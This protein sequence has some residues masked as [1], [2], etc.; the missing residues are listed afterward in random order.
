MPKKG[1]GKW[2]PAPAGLV[3]DFARLAGAV[4]EAERRRM[5]GYPCLFARGNM[6]AGLWQDTLILRLPEEERGDFLK[7]PSAVRFE[8]WPG[9]LM[10]EYVVVPKGMIRL[11]GLKKWI[12]RGYDYAASLP[13]KAGKKKR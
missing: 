1:M 9:R 13:A 11:P 3:E 10:K 8:P 5:F 4:P 12:R 7:L 6:F 2:K